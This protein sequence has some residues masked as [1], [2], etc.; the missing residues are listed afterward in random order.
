MALCVQK[1]AEERR[2]HTVLEEPA[3]AAAD[4]PGWFLLCDTCCSC[5]QCA[6]HIG[7]GKMPGTKL[8]AGDPRCPDVTC[9]WRRALSESRRPWVQLLRH[10]QT[11]KDQY[12]LQGLVQIQCENQHELSGHWRVA[13]GLNPANATAPG[14]PYAKRIG[15][16]SQGLHVAQTEEQAG[17]GAPERA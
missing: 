11:L 13:P 1:A 2:K 9:N 15:L 8:A 7:I 5:G 3:N 12:C 14:I 17:F 10:F 4:R 16:H 6:W